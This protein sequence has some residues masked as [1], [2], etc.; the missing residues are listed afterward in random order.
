MS[1]FNSAS[2]VIKFGGSLLESATAKAAF[3]S[4]ISQLF[5]FNLRPIL[6]HGGGKE[7]SK[8]MTRMGLVPQ[9]IQGLRV[10][11]TETMAITEMVL[12][13]RINK[14]LVG[15]LNQSGVPAIGLSGKDGALL[16]GEKMAAP[17]GED[18]GFV[19]DVAVCHTGV[20][21]MCVKNGYVPVVCSIG[22]G[23]GGET[24]N[25]NADF[26]ASGISM[27]IGAQTLIYITDAPGLIIAGKVQSE[28]TVD[29]AEALLFHPDVQGGMLPKLR[30]MIRC[31]RHGVSEVVM[32]DGNHPQVLLHYFQDQ[33]VCGTR[34][35]VS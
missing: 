16:I 18:L 27:A 11:D 17:T 12:A 3:I 35:S 32:L 34:I 7:I 13:G 24:L 8:W 5:H 30:E 29:A 20:L 15:L 31:L 33:V 26:A 1:D 10:T 25:L 14:D 9:F 28:L 23:Q 21:S 4:E 19:G 6:V 2:I 22:M